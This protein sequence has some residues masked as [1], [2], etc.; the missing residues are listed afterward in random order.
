MSYS[1]DYTL[2]QTQSFQNT[3]QMALISVALTVAVTA[4]SGDAVIDGLR[5]ALAAAVLNNPAVYVARFT[6]AAIEEGALTAASTDAQI[7][8][9]V[10]NVWS[11]IAGVTTRD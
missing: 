5:N 4:P 8:A 3:I 7:F 9:A 11:A 2:S 6:V 10:G 1:A